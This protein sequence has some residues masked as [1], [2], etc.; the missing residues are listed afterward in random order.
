MPNN[1]VNNKRI[2][3]NTLFLYVRMLVVMAV[4]LY[5]VRAILDLLGVV[6]YGIYNVV[7]GVVSMFSF[8]NGTLATSSQRYFS[9]ELAKGDLKRLNQWLCLNITTFSLFILAFI[10]IAETVGLWFVNYKMTIP[11]ERMFAANVVYQLSILTFCIHFFNIPYNALIIAHEKMSAFAYISI[12][13]AAAKLLIVYI[14]SIITWDKL[15]VYGLLMFLTSC[16]ITSSYIIYNRL[17]FSESRFRPYWNK[18]EMAEML[19]FSGWHFLG[20]FSVVVRSQGIN[21]LLNLFF[22]PAVNAARAVAF[23]VYHAISQLSGNFFTAVK[24]QIYKSYAKKE[25]NELFKLIMRS[26]IITSLLVS[27]LIYPFLANTPYI[28]SLWLKEV[29]QYAVVFTQLIMINGLIDSVNGPTAAAM[30]ATGKIRNYELIVG[31]AII[32]NLPISYAALK[33]GAE[34]TAT[35]LVSIS[36][37]IFTAIIRAYLLSR[38]VDVSFK[39]YVYMFFRLLLSTS[40]IWLIIYL[41]FYNSANN[42]WQLIAYSLLSVAITLTVYIT[43]AFEKNDVIYMV[44]YIKSKISK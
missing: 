19:G 21:I 6:D 37:S 43:I 39:K 28:L 27:I 24:P 44:N 15:V 18:K 34:P 2:A 10:V 3:K 11:E 22:N 1:T 8:L 7:G 20:T 33:L 16:G 41:S 40:A 25:Y 38:A 26:S 30:L 17:H 9:I 31:G 42:I 36:I 23:Q 14:L 12:V 5:T 32:M 29:P 13:E 35:M 4:G